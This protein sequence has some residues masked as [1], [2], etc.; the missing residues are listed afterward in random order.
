MIDNK[1]INSSSKYHFDRFKKKLYYTLQSKKAHYWT[2]E[3]K[4]KVNQLHPHVWYKKH[5]R[6]IDETLDFGGNSIWTVKG[7]KKELSENI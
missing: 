2:Y 5:E 3:E 4:T 1:I 7:A 6:H